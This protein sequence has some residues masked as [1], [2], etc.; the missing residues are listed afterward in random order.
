ME[1]ETSD[2]DADGNIGVQLFIVLILTAINAFLAA[3]ELAMLSCNKNKIRLLAE[4][5]NKAAK[6]VEK[7]AADQTRLLSTIQ[8]GITLAGLFSSA[9]AATSISELLA[10]TLVPLGISASI[11]ET[12]SL[13]AVT[14]VLSYFTLVF[15]ELF[16][17][18]VALK[19]PEATAMMGARVILVMRTIF[20]PFVKL[21]SASTNLLSRLFRLNE[22]TAE[23]ISEEEIKSVIETGVND[24]TLNYGEQK[25]IEG[26]FRFNDL[27]ATD[28]MTPRVNVFMVDIDDDSKKVIKKVIDEQFTR[29][30][31]YQ[32]SIDNII[33][34]INVK[35]LFSLAYSRPEKLDLIPFLRKP[36]FVTDRIKID[37]LFSIMQ[38]SHNQIA[39]LTDEFGG[40]TGIVT[41]EDLIEEIMGNIYDEYDGGCEYI[42]KINE[43]E[44]IV[45]GLTPV[46]DVNRELGTDIPENDENFDTVNGLVTMLLGRLPAKN[47]QCEL[48]YMNL[49][50]DV[51]GA[52]RNRVLKVR[53]T[54]NPTKSENT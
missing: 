33:G 15:G 25:M 24:G 16:P 46:Q 51:L 39:F 37:E 34:V 4:N 2:E 29:V 45:D 52:E 7:L 36:L 38:K 30:P 35:D 11:A 19:K 13:I 48:E 23:K 8:V 54:I 32:G 21:L 28:I 5:G 50:L 20:A 9:T 47:E 27:S 41:M 42:N 17:K 40:F 6:A 49:K 14:L 43:N 3:S 31:V 1:N 26:I 18:R 12:G 22:D 10:E 44:Y 53:I